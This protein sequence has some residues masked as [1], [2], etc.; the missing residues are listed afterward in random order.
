MEPNTKPLRFTIT[1]FKI[2]STGH[3]GG[4]HYVMSDIEYKSESRRLVIFFKEKSDERRLS[5]MSELI[6][7]GHLLDQGP[8]QSLSLL[9]SELIN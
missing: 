6:V 8:K 3:D 1:D 9:D 7:E 4:H 2:N 5:K